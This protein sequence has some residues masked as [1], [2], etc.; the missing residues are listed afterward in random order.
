[1]ASLIVDHHSSVILQGKGGFKE[2]CHS[3]DRVFRPV[4]NGDLI[5]R[6]YVDNNSHEYK[7]VKSMAGSKVFRTCYYDGVKTVEERFDLSNPLLKVIRFHFPS[8][9]SLLFLRQSERWIEID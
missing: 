4:P 3:P 8:D 5:N 1:M 2:V 6:D 7:S 9:G